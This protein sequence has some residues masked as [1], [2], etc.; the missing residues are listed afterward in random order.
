MISD[1]PG[2]V[3]A[4]AAS[5]G[6]ATVIA[7]AMVFFWYSDTHI[8]RS[9]SKRLSDVMLCGIL[10]G[11]VTSLLMFFEK[12]E[13]LCRTVLFSFSISFSIVVGTL[14]TKT[15]RIHRIFSKKAMRNGK[16]Q[17]IVPFTFVAAIVKSNQASAPLQALLILNEYAGCL[18]NTVQYIYLHV[19]A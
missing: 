3:V 14:L 9:S 6:S 19:L 11:Y 10:L 16:N 4:I 13:V 8:V 15:N 2:I 17:L 5:L 1:T 18:H 12:S 7:V